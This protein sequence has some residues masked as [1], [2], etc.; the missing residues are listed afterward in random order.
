MQKSAVT[1]KSDGVT[2][3]VS[4]CVRSRVEYTKPLLAEKKIRGTSKSKKLLC[5]ESDW[6]YV[7]LVVQKARK[8][9]TRNK[10]W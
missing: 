2:K 9:V 4:M 6:W 3:D 5:Q 7:G 8:H 10:F 1:S